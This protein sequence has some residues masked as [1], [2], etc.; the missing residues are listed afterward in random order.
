MEHINAPLTGKVYTPVA[1]S[2]RMTFAPVAI[3]LA[4]ALALVACGGALPTLTAAT[5]QAALPTPPSTAR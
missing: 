1:M 2:N 5:G 4:V 3:A